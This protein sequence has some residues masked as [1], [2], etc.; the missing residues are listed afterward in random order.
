MEIPNT[1]HVEVGSFVRLIFMITL[2]F[3]NGTSSRLVTIAVAPDGKTASLALDV[4]E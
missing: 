3:K 1:A 4:V 2:P